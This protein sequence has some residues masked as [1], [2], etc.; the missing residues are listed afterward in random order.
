MD[1]RVMYKHLGAT[2]AAGLNG[3]TRGVHI[4]VFDTSDIFLDGIYDIPTSI[5]E[6]AGRL[7]MLFDV[8][9]EGTTRSSH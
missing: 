8:N 4:N 2:G 7:C 3:G 6:R 5:W 9:V 1:I